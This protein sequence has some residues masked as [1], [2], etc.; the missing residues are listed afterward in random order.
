MTQPPIL[1]H[2]YFDRQWPLRADCLAIEVPLGRGRDGRLGVTYAALARRSLAM[3]AALQRWVERESVAAV[4]LP[5]TSADAYAAQLGILRA[6]AAYTSIDPAFPDAR[7]LDILDDAQAVAL[8]T[9]SAGAARAARLGFAPARI[10]ST[11]PGEFL[12]TTPAAPLARPPWF[13][14]SSLAYVIYTSGTTG[15]PKGVMVEHRAVS[16]LVAGDLEEFQLSPDDRVGHGSSH[17]YDSSVEEIWLAFAAGST[18]V[19]LDDDI[20]RA[21]PDLA[22]WL[23]RERISVLCPPPTLLR[24]MGARSAS[25]LSRLKLLYV[26][27]EALPR[28]VADE[29]SRGR[30]LV[31]GYGPTECAV[32]AVRG[33]VTANGRAVSIGRPIPGMRAWVLD[34]SLEEV[35]DGETGELCL[36][37]VGLARGYWN[38][39]ELTATKF[40]VHPRLGRIY[41]TGDLARRDS[42]GSLLCLGR[43]DSQVKLRGHRIELQEIEAQLARC[44]GVHA[45]ACRL[46]GD[47]SRQALV[48]FIVATDSSAPPSPDDLRAALTRTLPAV[49]VPSRF[50]IVEA[51]PTTTG[52]K[53]DRAALPELDEPPARDPAASAAPPDSDVEAVIE[54]A[55]RTALGRAGAVSVDDHFF[56][57]LGGD[58][59]RAAE[60]VTALRDMPAT[61]SLTVRD[62]Y[63]APTARALA[64]RVASAQPA[65]SSRTPRQADAPVT[66]RQPIVA[67]ALQA[68]WLTVQLVVASLVGSAVVLAL[69]PRLLLSWGLVPG[70]L[71]APLIIAIALVAYTVLAAIVAV[72]AKRVLIGRYTALSAPVWGTFYIRNWIVQRAVRL[73]PWA[74]VRG[75]ILEAVILRALGAKIGRR[76]HIHRGVDLLQGGWDLLEIGDDVTIG[77]D[78]AI[79]VVD[80]DEGQIIVAPVVLGNDVTLEV[81]AGVG[82]GTR[83][84]EGG[85][86]AALSNLPA[87]GHIPAGE[88]WDGVPARPAGRAPERVPATPPGRELTPGQ[89]AVVLLLLRLAVSLALAGPFVAV[90]MLAAVARAADAASF[91]A[92]LSAPTWDAASI[93]CVL[94]VGVVPVPLALLC[95]A[96]AI[97]MLGRSEPGV[98]SRWSVAY[99]RVWIKAGQLQAAGEWLSGTLLW[100]W[101]LRAAGMRVGPGCEIST[102]IDV[103]PELIDIGPGC[104]LA[105]GIY[106]GGPRVDR[107]TVTLAPTRLSSGVFI[108]N[109]A[110]IPGGQQLGHDVLIGVC[111]VADA[112][113]ERPGSSWFGHPPFELARRAVP[114]ADRRLTHDPPIVRYM[115]RLF[116]EALRFA[117][118][119]A[120]LVVSIVWVSVLAAA[121]QRVSLAAFILAAAPAATLG[122]AVCLC[123]LVL[124]LKWLLLGRVSPGEHP[125]WSCWCSRWDF[126]YVVWARLAQPV[127]SAFEGT[128]WLAWYLRAMGARIGRRV[129]LGGG[130]AQ[131]VDPDM[132][133]IDDEATV[134][135][136]FQAH[137]FEDRVLKIDRVRIGR[138]A[139]VAG[140]AVLLAGADVGARAW[141]APHSVVMKRERLKD[142]CAYEGCPTRA[143]TSR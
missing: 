61:A 70:I 40:P 123:L 126:L 9:D 80:L 107:G 6:G 35:A 113:C 8:V 39:P 18:L 11:D 56:A 13:T 89:Y 109:H 124:V 28:D 139:S 75:T 104:F 68:I 33:P 23:D 100:P 7:V 57:D 131:M 114:S 99:A 112:A 1:L 41:R 49:M 106:L 66:N 93:A 59:L 74:L 78:A 128:L 3:T 44:A 12:E 29:W 81:R 15:R 132:I 142:G 119:V 14:P 143:M 19:V 25:R 111:T 34:P 43:I 65:A 117:I 16:N 53:L 96:A 42:D 69:M 127:L 32:T 102:I 4:L 86:L 37:G 26:G 27:G 46:S 47:A 10:I 63:E 135:A 85:C 20:I 121:L 115:N 118:P 22:A 52:G 82:G 103:V 95:Q 58:S 94:A 97:R 136:L 83:I 105:D 137:T 17:A 84:D 129:V 88:R 140:G 101:W 120:P 108:G 64:A 67:S 71:I 36:G 76:V 133:R 110:V 134:H 2:E 141:V 122:A 50:R 21:G 130:F 54:I 91:L 51:L 62:V 87:G 24:A 72:A 90:A 92:W 48:A 30:R 79:R 138:Q 5:R 45:A 125:L 38:A 73:V 116:W 55:M 77:Q 98:I 60:L 31:N